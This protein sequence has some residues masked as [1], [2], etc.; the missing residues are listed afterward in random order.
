MDFNTLPA[1]ALDCPT[2]SNSEG[3]VS[4]VSTKYDF[5]VVAREGRGNCVQ[6]APPYAGFDQ[7]GSLMQRIPAHFLGGRLIRLSVDVRTEDDGS[8]WAGLWLRADDASGRSL[9]FNNMSD[10][11]IRGTTPWQRVEIETI[12]PDGIRWLNYGVLLV[13]SG[14]AWADDFRLEVILDSGEWVSLV[15]RTS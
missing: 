6:I 14:M 7:F 12:V 13:G 4:R 2:W 10:R 1:G 9:Y 15:P 3:Y 11:P 5:K 8:G